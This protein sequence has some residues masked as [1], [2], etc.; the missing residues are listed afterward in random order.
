MSTLPHP[1]VDVE[2]VSPTLPRG[3]WES[4]RR[5]DART[6]VLEQAERLRAERPV[7]VCELTFFVANSRS[8]LVILIIHGEGSRR[9]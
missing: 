4:K 7:I 1:G 2:T 6:Y 9:F 3:N 5:A 8:Q